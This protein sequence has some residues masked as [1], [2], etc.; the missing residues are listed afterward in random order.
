[1]E[2]AFSRDRRALL[3]GDAC[4]SVTIPSELSTMYST[5]PSTRVMAFKTSSI[6]MSCAIGC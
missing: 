1:M 4:I 3:D 5:A 6:T 2:G